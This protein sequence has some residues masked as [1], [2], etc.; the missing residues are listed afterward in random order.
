MTIRKLVSYA[1][2]ALLIQT[3]CAMPIAAAVRRQQ[4]TRSAKLKTDVARY[5]EKQTKVSVTMKDGSKLKGRITQHDDTAFTLTELKS[6]AARS[7]AYINVE[8]VKSAG[9]LS[10]LAKIGI[11]IGI[12]VGALALT[13]AVGKATCN[14]FGC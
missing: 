13:F 7:L 4:D 14:D 10:T 11:G 9:G 5:A 2:I 1:V 8:K 12:G 3:V 6:G